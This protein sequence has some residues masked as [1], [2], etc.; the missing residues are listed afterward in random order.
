MN[1]TLD[2]LAA[3]EAHFLPTALPRIPPTQGSQTWVAG[4]LPRA[5]EA[6]QG[7][8]APQR[9]ASP[10]HLARPNALPQPPAGH[11]PPMLN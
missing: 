4:P 11:S 7:M 2:S 1:G 8:P 10:P 6:S 3:T 9:R 5:P